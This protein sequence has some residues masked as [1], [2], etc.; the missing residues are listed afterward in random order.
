[1]LELYAHDC[2][3]GILYLLYL[4]E[5]TLKDPL[6]DEHSSHCSLEAP[7][8]GWVVTVGSR[9]KG[10]GVVLQMSAC[11]SLLRTLNLIPNSKK[12]DSKIH[13]CPAALMASPAWLTPIT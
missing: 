13:I 11:L 9:V 8:Q 1:M 6:T 5:V 7:G 12:T 10:L 3:P 2:E 4:T